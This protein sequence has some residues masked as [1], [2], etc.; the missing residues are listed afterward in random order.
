MVTGGRVRWGCTQPFWNL[1]RD[2]IQKGRYCMSHLSSGQKLGPTDMDFYPLFG[3]SGSKQGI[4]M[5]LSAVLVDVHHCK[6]W[7]WPNLFCTLSLWGLWRP[8]VT[9]ATPQDP[10]SPRAGRGKE[11]VSGSFRDTCCSLLSCPEQLERGHLEETEGHAFRLLDLYH[12]LCLCHPEG[13]LLPLF[14][15]YSYPM[16]VIY[17]PGVFWGPCIVL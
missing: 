10:T 3:I 1:L 11:D 17:P 7:V 6:A 9:M 16:L 2:P 13:S 8:E 12:Q 5:I 15:T 4:I 14:W